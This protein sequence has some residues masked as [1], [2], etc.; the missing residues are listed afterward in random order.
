[1]GT[2]GGSELWVARYDGPASGF[3]GGAAVVV[4]P[5]RAKVYVTGQSAGLTTGGDYATVA[6]STG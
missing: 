2:A 3:D 1:M 5:D 6:Y 4:S